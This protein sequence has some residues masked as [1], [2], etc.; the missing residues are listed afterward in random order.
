LA[1]GEN[2]SIVDKTRFSGL[3]GN[4]LAD[5]LSEIKPDEVWVTGVLTSICV[6]DTTG[7]LR[8]RDYSTVIPVDA[9]AD[10]DPVWHE[11]ALE[12]MKK[13]YGT[14]LTKAGAGGHEIAAA[15]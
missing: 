7:G 11:F 15:A 4:R 2:S 5:L 14:R 6:M 12:R 3:F 8:D 13:I 1:P 9:V 10:I